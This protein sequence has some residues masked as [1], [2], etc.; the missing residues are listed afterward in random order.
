VSDF[1]LSVDR[2]SDAANKNVPPL[3]TMVNE[4]QGNTNISVNRDEFISL[5]TALLYMVTPVLTDPF[6]FGPSFG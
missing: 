1:V 6:S 5:F 2:R 4:Q 3:R